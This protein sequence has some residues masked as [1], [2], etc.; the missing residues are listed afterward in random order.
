[1]T[2]DDNVA[3]Q[4]RLRA[5]VESRSDADDFLEKPGDV[6][7]VERGRLRSIVFACPDGCGSVLTINLDPRAGKAWRFYRSP[8][9]ISLH[10]SVWRDG[11]CRAHFV[12]W[13]DRLLWSGRRVSGVS[14]PAY[15]EA[16]E[17]VVFAALKGDFR[18]SDEI[19][20]ELDLIPYEVA[21]TADR[22]ARNGLAE[23]RR[24][25]HGSLYRKV[26]APVPVEEKVEIKAGSEV[27]PTDW[28]A[29]LRA[30]LGI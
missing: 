1:M 11:G 30:W 25:P 3:R 8:K 20:F 16:N 2:N 15:D 10:P 27:P 23:E 22:L 9:G 17:H 19:A 7:L 13:Q 6:V 14:E 18:S 21:R 12:L 4:I 28:L 5:T 29:R 24:T 26:A